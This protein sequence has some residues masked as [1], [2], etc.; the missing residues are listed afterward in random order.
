MRSVVR[1]SAVAFLLGIADPAHAV[2]ISY[3]YSGHF[4][5]SWSTGG[6]RDHEVGDPFWGTITYDPDGP[7]PK[8][9]GE[10]HWDYTLQ[11]GKTD[12]R[13]STFQGISQSPDLRLNLE[14]HSSPLFSIFIIHLLFA[15][16]GLSGS[17][18]VIDPDQFLGGSIQTSG[19]AATGEIDT[20]RVVPEPATLILL[21][22]AA[23]LGGVW[24]GIKKRQKTNSPSILRAVHPR[25]PAALE[26]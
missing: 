20:F 25:F 14:D 22:T 3:E 6:S 26:R 1:A 16:G 21:A 12:S 18:I 17:P 11:F 4:T 9:F 10:G 2:P 8:L 23:G 24:Q 13:S 19:H 7:P 15:P 5:T